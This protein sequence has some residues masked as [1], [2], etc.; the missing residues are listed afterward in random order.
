MKEDFDFSVSIVKG[1]AMARLTPLNN[2]TALTLWEELYVGEHSVRDGD[3]VEI[4]YKDI[5]TILRDFYPDA[6]INWSSNID[7]ELSSRLMTLSF[8]RSRN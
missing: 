5:K 3:S 8:T 4:P 7:E 2:E 6:K 1:S